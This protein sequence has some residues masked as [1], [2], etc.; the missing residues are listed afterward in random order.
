MLRNIS[1][2]VCVWNRWNVNLYRYYG[3]SNNAL[4]MSHERHGFTLHWRH[5]ERGGIS[6]HQP[7]DC[8]LNRLFK[9]TWKTHQSSASLA[10]LRGIH[11]WPLRGKCF[12]LMTSSWSSPATWWPNVIINNEC[13][14]VYIS[15]IKCDIFSPS[16]ECHSVSN[17]WELYCVF[18]SLLWLPTKEISKLCINSILWWESNSDQRIPFT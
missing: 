14:K 15:V 12:H 18:S 1:P 5:N 17:Y 6:D 13:Y 11:R 2:C 4:M 8:L 7:H 10:F 16:H 3:D 9:R